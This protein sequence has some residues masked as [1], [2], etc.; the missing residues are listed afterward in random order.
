MSTATSNKM[1]GGRNGGKGRGGGVYGMYKSQD[2]E[3]QPLAAASV[4]TSHDGDASGAHVDSVMQHAEALGK[5]GAGRLHDLT[6]MLEGTDLDDDHK[7]DHAAADLDSS[8]F[9]LPAST[10]HMTLAQ[11]PVSSTLQN[12]FQVWP[13]ALLAEF[14]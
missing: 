4:D 12:S 14:S 8:G 10:A 3:Q 2:E 6:S 5:G 13:P 7:K 11:T 1:R 9:N